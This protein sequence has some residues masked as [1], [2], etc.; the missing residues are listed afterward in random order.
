M[1]YLNLFF[2]LLFL[3]QSANAQTFAFAEAVGIT[4][5]S[6]LYETVSWTPE[7]KAELIAALGTEMGEKVILQ[8]SSKSWPS[9]IATKEARI[10]NQAQFSRYGAFYLTTVNKNLA[11]LFIPFIENRFMPEDMRPETDVYFAIPLQ[12]ILSKKSLDL[13]LAP[14]FSKDIAV[15][16]LD[17][18]NNFANL[19]SDEVQEP[20]D[21]Q[22]RLTGCKVGLEKAY[23]VFFYDEPLSGRLAFRAAFMGSADPDDVYLTYQKLVSQVGTLTLG[24]CTLLI[25]EEFVTGNT[26]S[27]NFQV[28]DKNGDLDPAYEN[29]IISVVVEEIEVMNDAEEFV[30][31]WEPVI[32]IYK[33]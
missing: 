4:D 24:C 20:M 8:S 3:S 33:N 9:G 18:K 31:E 25:Q 21:G 19:T 15:I 13:A 23:E 2:A 30:K 32:Y 29:M 16:I 14:D 28:F 17:F 7:L 1:R 22:P 11:I 10:R 27:Q 6:G 5:P 26:R 12:S